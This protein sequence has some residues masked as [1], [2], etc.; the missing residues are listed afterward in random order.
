M[1][2]NV[3]AGKSTSKS[4]L[5]QEF[6]KIDQKP[7]NS[8][9]NTKREK[10]LRKTREAKTKIETTEAQGQQSFSSRNSL[11]TS[12]SFAS[13]SAS[14]SPQLI[15]NMPHYPDCDNNDTNLLNQNK[16]SENRRTTGV[17]NAQDYS[18]LSSECFIKTDQGNMVCLL[19]NLK[20]KFRNEKTIL[21][22]LSS[23]NHNLSYNKLR[24]TL[25]GITPNKNDIHMQSIKKF[26][27]QRYTENY[28]KV[29][30]VQ[31]RLLIVE[32]F[33]KIVKFIDPSSDCRLIGSLVS[34]TSLKSSNIN[35]ELDHPNSKIFLEDPRSKKSIHHKL[36]DPDADYGSQINLH[37]IHYDLAANAIT[38]LYNVMRFIRTTEPEVCGFRLES[39][40]KDLMCKIPKVTVRHVKSQIKLDLICYS[41]SSYEQAVLFNAYLSLDDRSRI[42]AILV[43]YWAKTCKIDN[44]DKGT[45]P[46]EIFL[47]LVIYYLQRVSPPVLPCLHE[48]LATSS[49]DRREKESRDL[50][51]KLDLGASQSQSK[52]NDEADS[53][54]DTER[55]D[56]SSSQI[57][58][59]AETC[60]EYVD[61]E[62][63][64]D[65]MFFDLESEEVKNLNWRS[66]NQSP[67]HVLFIDFLKNMIEEF[68]NL[69]TIITI[70]TLSPVTLQDKDWI[71][72]VK[73]IENPSKPRVNMSRCI[74]T[75]R[76]FEYIKKCFQHGYY[77]LT[78]MPFDSRLIQ[79]TELQTDP[80]DF[81]ELYVNRKKLDSYYKRRVDFL[82]RPLKDSVDELLS[83]NLF[84]RDIEAIS[85]AYR[86]NKETSANPASIAKLSTKISKMY[87][88]ELLIPRDL[89]ATTFCWLCRKNGHSRNNCPKLT[90]AR[91]E[92]NIYLRKSELDFTANFDDHFF[93][94]FQG[95]LITKQLSTRHEAILAELSH[96][97]NSRTDMDCHLQ[98]FGSTVNDLG[99]YDSDL[100]ICMT[101]K[102]NRTG[103]GV[104]CVQVLQV[105]NTILEKVEDV[106]RLEPILSARVPIIR[107]EY[108]GFDV[109][110]SMYNQ[111]AIY[112]SKLLKTYS[113][114]DK[115]VAQLFYL[116]KRFAK[117]SI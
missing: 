22:H 7:K 79:K 64:E 83:L 53:I 29:E 99:S 116:V 72:Q 106:T 51:G 3:K 62:D 47:I 67:I 87:N 77:Y 85:S 78:S 74:G 28:L 76:T 104:D 81:I 114:F 71:T 42:L 90:I 50:L 23:E 32:E 43:K 59:C 69:S 8:S 89:L 34:G 101:L 24:F 12:P 39:E 86:E 75:V 97:I 112:N 6:L 46:P 82:Q 14:K 49:Q 15:Y 16:P 88:E 10:S 5:S 1:A 35:L 27:T 94:L 2:S 21:R 84:A 111:C 103:K 56:L 20:D 102:H 61:E 54:K 66:T 105:V 93:H 48:A 38:T 117:V 4:T 41:D 25:T 37:T 100:D 13:S 58:N 96:I 95:H 17:I 60:E 52:K 31:D 19:C 36:V 113:S 11:R 26:L 91:L 115:R 80:R 63:E 45:F 98:L 30:E 55:N 107:F 18:I 44:P 33:R 9:V 108:K 110:L 70:R 73:A 68:N 109:D 65:N 40:P 92:E 57:D